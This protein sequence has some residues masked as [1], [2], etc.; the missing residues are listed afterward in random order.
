M[1]MTKI[2]SK[3]YKSKS[4]LINADTK[5]LQ[6]NLNKFY[7]T[8]SLKELSVTDIIILYLPTPLKNKNIPDLTHKKIY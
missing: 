4:Y 6:R 1:T 3:L 5:V 2:R 7:P 8:N